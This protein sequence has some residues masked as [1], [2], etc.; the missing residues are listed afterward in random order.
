MEEV[1]RGVRVKFKACRYLDGKP[2]PEVSGKAG[3]DTSDLLKM[4]SASR[5]LKLSDLPCLVP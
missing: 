1:C 4:I 2:T 5:V 3:I